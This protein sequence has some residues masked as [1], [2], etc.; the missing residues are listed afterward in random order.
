MTTKTLIAGGVVLLLIPFLLLSFIVWPSSDDYAVLFLVQEYQQSIFH[1]YGR[2]Y[3]TWVGRYSTLLGALL[4]PV[5]VYHLWFYRFLVF[6]TWVLL[7]VA[8]NWF[9]RGVLVKDR[10]TLS[11]W[12]WA[13]VFV[14]LWVQA[15][16]GMPDSFYWHSGVVVYTWP[17]IFFFFAAGGL[18]RWG[19]SGVVMRVLVVGAVFLMVGF[20]E[21]AALLA[22]MIVAGV[23]FQGLAYKKQSGSTV[24]W[25]LLS[26]VVTGILILLLSPGNVQRMAFFSEGRDLFGAA[27]I[28]YTSLV[29]LNGVNLISLPLWLVLWVLFP[30]LNHEHFHTSL[31][32]FLSW[33][34]LVVLV[35]GQLAFYGFMLIPAWSMGIVPPLRI[36]NFLTPLWL[37]WFLWLTISLRFYLA[38]DKTFVWSAVSGKSLNAMVLLIGLSIM[39]NFV[40]VPGGD[41][42]YGGNVPRAWSD[43]VF[44]AAPFNRAMHEREALIY[45]AIE[46]GKQEVVLPA[47]KDPPGTIFFLDITSDPDHWINILY[48]RHYGVDR[49]SLED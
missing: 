45:A 48:A 34:P 15:V 13:G 26:A 31:Q 39:V 8:V 49:V 29:K 23:F 37:L 4:S 42:V 40:K 16:P 2:L 1:I 19:Q 11:H 22:I 5:V 43:L 44:R 14:L 38:K 35:G 10:G 24:R 25:W 41:Y 27:Y 7:L 20:N 32:P 17:L 46:E 36:Y 12:M 18:L 30:L 21:L 33:H 9:W 3:S 6:I 47:L 28:A